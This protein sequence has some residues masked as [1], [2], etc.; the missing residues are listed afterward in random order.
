MKGP[1]FQHQTIVHKSLAPGHLSDLTFTAASNVCGSSVWNFLARRILRW[2]LDFSEIYATLN[3][4]H[5]LLLYFGACSFLEGTPTDLFQLSSSLLCLSHHFSFLPSI[6]PPPSSSSSPLSVFFFSIVLVATQIM[7]LH[8]RWIFP[9]CMSDPIPFPQFHLHCLNILSL[10][11]LL[12][13]VTRLS[14]NVGLSVR[15]Y[16]RF[17]VV[18]IHWR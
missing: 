13:R 10:F 9:Q 4:S 5:F 11:A 14:H 15:L 2:F 7:F 18:R 17:T 12:E 1:L 16:C 6:L 8:D 3:W